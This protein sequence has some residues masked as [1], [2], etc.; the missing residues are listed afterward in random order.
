MSGSRHRARG[1]SAA[2]ALVAGVLALV[3]AACGSA[4]APAQGSSASG[5]GHAGAA[6]GRATLSSWPE[7]GLDP[8]RSNATSAS[9]G[10]D[11]GNV[12]SLRRRHVSLPGTVDSS[13]IYLHDAS[14]D[15]A[16]HD[17]VVVTTTYGKTLAIDAGSGARLWTFT[18]PGYARWAGSAQITTATPIADPDGRYV[19]AAAPDGDIYKLALSDGAE[20]HEGGW[21]V[22]VTRDPTHEKIA[23]PLNIDGGY[24]VV[25]TGGYIGDIP[26]YQGHVVAIS[27]AGGHIRAVFNSL[28][29]NRHHII[30]P[31][32]CPAS[33]SAMWSRSGVVVEPGGGRVLVGTGNAPWNGRTDFGDS[34]LELTFPALRLRQEFTPTDQA[35]LNSDDLD[36]GTGGPALLG[37]GEMLVG[38]KDGLMRVVSLAR[39]DGHRPSSKHLLGGELQQIATPGGGELITAPAVWAHGGKT[40]VFVAEAGGTAAYALRGG[41]LRRLWETSTPGTSPVVA[42]G[43][44]Y[45]YNPAAGGI[46]VYSPGSAHPLAHLAGSPGHWNSPI[47]V[48]GHVIEPEGDANEHLVSGGLD[49]FSVR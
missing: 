48:D 42:G 31:S 4:S 22:S 5:A 24:V 13:P 46:D 16:A 41:R 37:D 9:V 18:P 39:M 38:G 8:Q 11:A 20:V 1:A 27:R 10:I 44:V 40:T 23:A 21:P 29:A 43:L 35:M 28:C 19:Y 36:F 12:A 49:I 26:P 30:T 6:A 3:A 33:D 7:F 32:S 34:A 25:A 17:V 2:G 15:G 45:V 47:A 14:V